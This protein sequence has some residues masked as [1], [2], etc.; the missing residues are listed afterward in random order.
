M[1]DDQNGA[2]R[3]GWQSLPVIG[4]P[5]RPVVDRSAPPE[6][7]ELSGNAD[8]LELTILAKNALS[9]GYQLGID[10]LVFRPTESQ[11]VTA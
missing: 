5:L 10:Y 3:M 11:L 7:V 1:F 6:Q 8:D 9:T 2:N 4:V